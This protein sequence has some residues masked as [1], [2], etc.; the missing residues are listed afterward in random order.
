M[1]FKGNSGQCVVLSVCVQ[2]KG[3]RISLSLSFFSCV[4]VCTHTHVHVHVCVP[5][6]KHLCA[7]VCI[8]KM[9]NLC[10]DS[11]APE[12][13][14]VCLDSLY[15]PCTGVMSVQHHA[16]PRLEIEFLG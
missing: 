16:K 2:L 3:E 10:V 11:Q 1:C 8:G 4:C 15:L 14:V 6:F 5:V 7:W 13:F 9:M 12:T